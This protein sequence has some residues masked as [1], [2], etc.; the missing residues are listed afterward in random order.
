MQL[1]LRERRN[2]SAYTKGQNPYD[3]FR[4]PTVKHPHI[5]KNNKAYKIPFMILNEENQINKKYYYQILKSIN[6]WLTSEIV[7][8]GKVSC[9]MKIAMCTTKEHRQL[10]E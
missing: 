6:M 5:H 10:P 1:T 3:I 4:K 7:A 8:V 9:E 2:K